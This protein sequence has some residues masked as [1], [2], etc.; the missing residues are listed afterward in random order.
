MPGNPKTKQMIDRD[1]S[2]EQPLTGHHNPLAECEFFSG[3]FSP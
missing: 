1:A 3:V 2:L